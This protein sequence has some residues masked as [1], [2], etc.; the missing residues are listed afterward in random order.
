M[1]F[2]HIPFSGIKLERAG[3]TNRRFEKC[4][5]VFVHGEIRKNFFSKI[6][7][8]G[9]ILVNFNKGE[10]PYHSDISKGAYFVSGFE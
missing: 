5:S 2:H 6:L 7:A 8:K 4:P 3:V 1:R 9:G 10:T